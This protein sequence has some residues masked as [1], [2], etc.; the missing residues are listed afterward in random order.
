MTV[1]SQ[2]PEFQIVGDIKI[3][4]PNPQLLKTVNIKGVPI[5]TLHSK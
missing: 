5:F 1:M 4:V 2:T 3:D